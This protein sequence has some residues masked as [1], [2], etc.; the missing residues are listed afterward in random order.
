EGAVPSGSA[1]LLGIAGFLSRGVGIRIFVD[2]TAIAVCGGVFVVP[3]YA[4]IQQRSDEAARA[5]T[6]AA[7]NIMNALYMTG[8]AAITAL[9]LAVGFRTPDLWLALGILNAGVALWICRLLPPDT[10]G[11]LAEKLPG[12]LSRLFNRVP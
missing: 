10:L 4:I 11:W 1:D 6:I 3:L 7:M 9:L 2:L 8:A 12:R 5:R